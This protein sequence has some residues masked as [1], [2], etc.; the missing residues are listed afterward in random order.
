MNTLFSCLS[1]LVL[2]SLPMQSASARYA[3]LTRLPSANVSSSSFLALFIHNWVDERHPERGT[4]QKLHCGI[5]Y[6]IF[7]FEHEVSDSAR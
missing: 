1:L 5:G 4:G 3:G 2:G 6:M 7:V